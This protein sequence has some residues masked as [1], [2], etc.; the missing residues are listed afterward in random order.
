ML[1]GSAGCAG[2]ARVTSAAEPLPAALEPA[3]R[4]MTAVPDHSWERLA[5]PALAVSLELPD[6]AGWRPAGGRDWVRLVHRSGEAS[7]ELRRFRAEA[8]VRTSDCARRAGFSWPGDGDVTEAAREIDGGGGD[9]AVA[10]EAGEVL[11]RRELDGTDGLRIELL[12]MAGA[13]DR[14]GGLGGRIEASAAGLRVCV[15]ARAQ[16]RVLGE[17][18]EAEL[19]RQL[20]LFSSRALP[21]LALSTVEDRVQL[22]E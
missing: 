22:A 8:T 6:A 2:T 9:S 4:G 1:V 18:R 20:A 11:E 14:A 7:I 12:V 17:G 3:P 15:A 5:V 10:F 16:V 13:L 19:A 21:S